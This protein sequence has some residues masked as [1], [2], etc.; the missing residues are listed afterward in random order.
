M[1]C[2]NKIV[3]VH[4]EGSSCEKSF[5]LFEVEG[6]IVALYI[7][8]WPTFYAECRIDP[9]FGPSFWEYAP[10]HKETYG[11]AKVS[12]P[13]TP[14]RRLRRRKQL[15][16][17]RKSLASRYYQLLTGH[18]TGSFVL[19]FVSIIFPFSSGGHGEAGDRGGPVR[20]GTRCGS[21][22]MAPRAA[23][24]GITNTRKC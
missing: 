13:R 5:F 9:T 8:L 12:L 15:R 24:S 7:P 21:R 23:C 20:L 17:I 22:I 6:K 2:R 14:T 10:R 4:S 1:G 11:S 3:V 16:R 19:S 18:A